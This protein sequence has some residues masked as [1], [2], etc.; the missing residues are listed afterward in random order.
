MYHSDLT[1]IFAEPKLQIH[2]VFKIFHCLNIRELHTIVHNPIFREKLK[3]K[4]RKYVESRRFENNGSY[5]K[6]DYWNILS[7]IPNWSEQDM[8]YNLVEMNDIFGIPMIRVLEKIAPLGFDI[9]H[10]DL[11]PTADGIRLTYNE[12]SKI[13]NNSIMKYAIAH[14][15]KT[16]IPGLLA[17]E[18]AFETLYVE[19]EVRKNR[20]EIILDSYINKTLAYLSY[21]DKGPKFI[22]WSPHGKSCVYFP[23]EYNVEKIYGDGEGFI[24]V[25]TWKNF[26]IEM[27]I[28]MKLGP[29]NQFSYIGEEK[30]FYEI[31]NLLNNQNIYA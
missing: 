9:E 16:N 6:W 31:E 14:E 17:F 15:N 23:N 20:S 25:I 28:K 12:K 7:L 22:V 8:I 24:I 4:A 19:L 5:S 29:Q 18:I 13:R 1:K 30:W 26:E 27:K 3:E 21:T 11:R 10:A 2:I